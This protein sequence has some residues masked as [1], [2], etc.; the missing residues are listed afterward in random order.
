LTSTSSHAFDEHTPGEQTLRTLD[1]LQQQGKI[2]YPAVSYTC[3]HDV[4]FTCEVPSSK[5]INP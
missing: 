2:L 4:R 5:G 1:A 3:D